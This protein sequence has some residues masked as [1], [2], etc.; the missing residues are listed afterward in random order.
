MSVFG[1]G[2]GGGDDG[3]TDPVVGEDGPDNLLGGV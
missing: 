1:E 2:S 3:G